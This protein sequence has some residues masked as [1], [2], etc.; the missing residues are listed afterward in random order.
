MKASV[1]QS[2]GAPLA[3]ID[4][5]DPEIGAGDLLIKVAY[6]GVCGTDLH[7]TQPGIAR[8]LSPGIILGHEFAGEVVEVGR[9]AGDHWRTGERVTVM[10]FRP[11]PTCGAVCKDGFDIICPSVSYLGIGLPGG[12]AQYVAV[13]AAQALKLP[14]PVDL[15]CGALVEP[16]A[17]GYHAV[18]K[19]GSILGLRVLVIGAGPV[20]QAV[21]LYA[22]VAGARSVVVSEPREAAR[23]RAAGLGATATLDPAAGDAGVAFADL[24]GGPPEV[25][26]ECVGTPGM[27]EE[28]VRIAPLF[29]RVIVVGACMEQDHLY[30]MV[31]L[32]KELTLTFVLG[33]D[34]GD[35]AFVIDSLLSGRIDPHPLVTEIAEFDRF[36]AAFEALRGGAD[37]CKLLLKP[38]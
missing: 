4:L 21:A 25:I 27:I 16:L 10:P 9:S 30:P 23:C 32:T 13:G 20:G 22:R 14:G 17:V 18:R 29:G 28:A 36:S 15:I 2:Q 1:F 6:S 12:N 19:A 31:A 26:F 11:C 37:S 34:R 8:A 24:V 33:H 7:L 3:V 35:F 5:P 38:N